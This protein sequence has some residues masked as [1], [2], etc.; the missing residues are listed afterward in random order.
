ML[1]DRFDSPCINVA[2]LVVL[3]LGHNDQQLGVGYCRLDDAR[4]MLVDTCHDLTALQRD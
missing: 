1:V 3:F 2:F 4:R